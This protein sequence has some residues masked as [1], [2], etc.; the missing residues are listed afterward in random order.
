[1]K[2]YI[3]IIVFCLFSLVSYSQVI[4]PLMWG[5]TQEEVTATMNYNNCYLYS[6]DNNSL[7]TFD[8]ASF[9]NLQVDG[10]TFYFNERYKDGLTS[11]VI[12]K[13]VNTLKKA[14]NLRDKW[15]RHFSS[16]YQK[17]RSSKKYIGY[18]IFDEYHDFIGIIYIHK[19]YDG[20]RYRVNFGNT[21]LINIK[22]Y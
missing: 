15:M 8:I 3:A 13:E 18:S 4:Y 6:L 17:F 12:Y 9:D 19:T 14:L 20:K 1:M 16:Y 11:I 22:A 5:M 7:I 2:K 21:S 10:V